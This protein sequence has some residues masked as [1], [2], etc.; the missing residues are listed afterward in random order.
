M[1]VRHSLGVSHSFSIR[2]VFYDKMNLRLFYFRVTKW[3]KGNFAYFK[4]S[5]NNAKRFANCWLILIGALTPFHFNI[6]FLK[7]RFDMLSLCLVPS[8]NKKV[9]SYLLLLEQQPFTALQ[10]Q[11]FHESISIY[12][13]INRNFFNSKRFP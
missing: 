1:S 8:I 9:S 5:Y 4:S 13:K 3:W 11:N 6:F 12:F 7:K 10:I 2:N